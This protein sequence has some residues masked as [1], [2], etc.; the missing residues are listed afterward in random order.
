MRQALKL[1]QNRVEA[2]LLKLKHDL[3]A[4]V[5]YLNDEVEI[6]LTNVMCL[7]TTPNV[8]RMILLARVCDDC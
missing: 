4:R 3:A 2:G 5:R 7:Q 8:N 1:R 6:L